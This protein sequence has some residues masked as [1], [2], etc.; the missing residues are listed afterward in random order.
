LVALVAAECIEVAEC[1]EAVGHTVLG[2]QR[3]PGGVARD[4]VEYLSTT[5]QL[6][7]FA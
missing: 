5:N 1:I 3:A 2:Q 7:S 4:D 6:E